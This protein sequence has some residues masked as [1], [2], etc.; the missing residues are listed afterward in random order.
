MR[1]EAANLAIEHTN[2]LPALGH[3]DA[4]ELLGGKAKGVLLIDWRHI[5]QPVEIRN[6]LQVG[7]VLDQLLRAAM[8][9]ADMR[10]D[11]LDDLAVELK[12]KTQH[13]MR[14]RMLRPEVDRK[15]SG[16]GICHQANSFAFAAFAASRVLNLSHE[17]TKRSCRPS[18]IRSMPSCAFT[19]NE[20]RGPAISAHSTSTVTVWP[21]NVAAR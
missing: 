17:T 12:H 1:Q 10:I 3:L 9:E 5:V 16:G 13:T 14:R 2:D 8:E 7:L 21:G 18:P 6:R 4:E 15:V 20:I 19:L 11:A